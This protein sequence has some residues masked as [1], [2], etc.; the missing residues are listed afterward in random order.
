MSVCDALSLQKTL[1]GAFQL[2]ANGLKQT[3]VIF[4]SVLQLVLA[5]VSANSAKLLA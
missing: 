2:E 4:A 5:N 1:V 3:V